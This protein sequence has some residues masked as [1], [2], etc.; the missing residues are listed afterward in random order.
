MAARLPTATHLLDR[1][2]SKT[3]GRRRFQGAYRRLHN[4]ALVG[5]NYGC[6]DPAVNG[7]LAFLDRMARTW[8]GRTVVAFDVGASQGL[9][10]TALLERASSAT[11]HAFEPMPSAFARLSANLGGRAHLHACALGATEGR[12]EM[13]APPGGDPLLG[14]LASLH[15]RDLSSYDLAVESVGSV[16]VQT[17][18]DVC[19]ASDIARIDLLKLDTEGHEL[20]VLAGARRLLD[21]RAID[22][23]QFEFGGANVDAR[24]FLRDIVAVL[25]PTHRVFR[26][27]R[28]GV[29]PVRMNEREEIFTY[30]NYVALAA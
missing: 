13:F 7:E 4:V 11:V 27:L 24:V 26:L 19:E 15:A 6:G 22:A 23:I 20:S 30:A 1:M 5:L 25:A 29:E 9:W 8:H 17:L 2:A 28:D 16:E 3:Y 10:S 14:E 18:D 12:A 21:A